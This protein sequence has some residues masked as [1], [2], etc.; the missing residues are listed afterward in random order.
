MTSLTN[1]QLLALNRRG[2]IPGPNE[3]EPAFLQRV[4]YCLQLSKHLEVPVQTDVLAEPNKDMVYLYDTNI[5]WIPVVF[6]N[7]RL[8]PW[9]GGC[10]WIFQ[11]SDDTPT[12]AFIQLRKVFA[13]QTYFLGIYS[14]DELMMHELV[15]VGRMKFEEPRFEELLAYETSSSL[16]RRWLGP[17]IQA[18][19]E[20]I[21]FIMVLVAILILDL[22]FVFTGHLE[23]LESAMYLKIL[24]LVMIAIAFLRLVRKRI[25]FQRC[26]ERLETTLQCG[27]EARA[28]AYRLTDKEIV[29]FGKFTSDQIRQYA[30][31]QS[32]SEL[33]WKVIALAYF[34]T[35]SAAVS[36]QDS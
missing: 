7:E 33:R 6:S 3:D 2:L 28:V 30:Q 34:K 27:R 18:S 22:Y 12:A 36:T 8:A 31:V 19:W 11:F 16:F 9:H 14:R 15:H 24:P 1:D 32:Q 23:G 5:D 26:I 4:E 10:A 21:L 17:L 13:H 20:S 29:A 25:Q 35:S